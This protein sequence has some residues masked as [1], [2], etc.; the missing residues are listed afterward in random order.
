MDLNKIAKDGRYSEMVEML[1]TE[2][3]CKPSVHITVWTHWLSAYSEFRDSPERERAL[4]RLW[5]NPNL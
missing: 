2:E 3:H 5:E 4:W 1:P